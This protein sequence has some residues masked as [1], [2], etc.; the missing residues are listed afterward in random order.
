MNSAYMRFVEFFARQGW[1]YY[2]HADQPVLYLH[3]HGE[4]AFWGCRAVAGVES[5]A[6]ISQF[7]SRVPVNQRATCAELL[8]RLNFGL[9]HACFELDFK[10]GFVR[11]RTSQMGE[12]NAIT[13]QNIADIVFANLC[14]FDHHFCVIMRVLHGG[15][16]PKVAL[17]EEASKKPEQKLVTA[18]RFE[19]N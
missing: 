5:I 17:Q 15:V 1:T 11:V 16:S 12:A 13:L 6:F 14:A 8:T 9:K 19:F 3:F 18:G 2:Q 10:D 7:P 4:N